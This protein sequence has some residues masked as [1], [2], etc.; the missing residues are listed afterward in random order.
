MKRREVRLH[1]GEGG[2]A[3]AIR[4]IRSRG[5]NQVNKV[6]DDGTVEVKL[7]LRG[8]NHN[9]ELKKFL[10]HIL[11]IPKKRI[12]VIAGKKKSEKLVSIIDVEP[13]KVQKE[14]LKNIS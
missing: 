5:K 1:N 4:L 12:N 14:I 10:S 3:L 11:D 13:Q 7:A 9:E 8:S 2:S 6:L